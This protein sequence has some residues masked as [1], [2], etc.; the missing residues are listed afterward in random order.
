[1]AAHHAFVGVM[2]DGPVMAGPSA[3]SRCTILN[4]SPLPS[5]KASLVLGA[6]DARRPSQTLTN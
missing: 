1:M 2:S 4:L 3:F 5:G 6:Q